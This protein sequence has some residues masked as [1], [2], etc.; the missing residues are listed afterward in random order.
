ME[1]STGNATIYEE[2]SEGFRVDTNELFSN[3]TI[4]RWEYESLRNEIDALQKSLRLK[5]CNFREIS[6]AQARKDIHQFIIQKKKEGLKSI[7]TINIVS[8]LGL[9]ANQVEEIINKLIKRKKIVEV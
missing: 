9:P 7:R 3:V 8:S 6:D 5:E 4:T 2:T 1:K